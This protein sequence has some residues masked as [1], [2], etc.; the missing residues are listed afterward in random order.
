MFNKFM[1]QAYT[2]PVASE[3]E[4]NLTISVDIGSTQTRTM[5][6]D[7]LGYMT[8]EPLIVDTAYIPVIRQLQ[9]VKTS[10][11]IESNLEAEIVSSSINSHIIKGDMRLLYNK[12]SRN[13]ASCTSK[14]EQE[15]AYNSILFMLGLNALLYELQTNKTYSLH[16]TK[17]VLSLPSEDIGSNSRKDKLESKLKGIVDITFP[18]FNRSIKI[19]IDEIVIHSEVA[20][21]AV[22]YMIDCSPDPTRNYVFID[23]GGRNKSAILYK[24]GRVVTESSVS[25]SGGG[26]NYLRELAQIVQNTKGISKPNTVS[27]LNALPN[28]TLISGIDT[29]DIIDSMEEAK[30]IFAEQ[31]VDTVLELLDYNQMQLQDISYIICSGRTM[32][33]SERKGNI[34][35]QS[36]VT[37][38]ESIIHDMSPQTQ[39]KR[40]DNINAVIVGLNYLSMK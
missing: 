6:R 27:L 19:S 5:L 26:E 1:K 35:S 4:S 40:S 17:L 29:I 36:M 28:A 22:Q 32:L 30:M 2:Q 9:D 31:M 34:V 13:L 12:M 16:K 14:L 24:N 10:D 23:C 33:P 18:R 15:G 37:Y 7:N 38:F 8:M 25:K 11:T 3:P 20:S 21:A 39:C